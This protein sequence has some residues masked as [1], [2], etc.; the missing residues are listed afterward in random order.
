MRSLSRCLPY[1]GNV[2]PR[3]QLGYG[4]GEVNK[5]IPLH[6]NH[7]V[8]MLLQEANR[9]LIHLHY[10]I[11]SYAVVLISNFS[12][13]LCCMAIIYYRVFCLIQQMLLTQGKYKSP[14][15]RDYNYISLQ[16][17]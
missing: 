9:Y 17:L 12:V 7:T 5:P 16:S 2:L 8:V 6:H 10:F 1:Y 13:V 14:T 4:N 11:T 3:P 15:G